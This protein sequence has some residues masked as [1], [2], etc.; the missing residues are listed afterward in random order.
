MR[1]VRALELRGRKAA[2]SRILPLITAALGLL[3][4]LVPSAARPEDSPC[5]HTAA[6]FYS[7]DSVNLAARLHAAPSNCADYYISLIPGSDNRTPRNG[8]AATIRANGPQFH[9]MQEVRLRPWG[10]WVQQTGNTWYQAGVTA[11][12]LMATAGANYDITGGDTWA[13]NEVGT[14]S[15]VDMAEAVFNGDGTARQD[16]QDFVRGLYTGEP[17]MPPAPGLVFVADPTQIT[18]DLGGY[19]DGLR[20]WFRDDA[21]W[22][23]MSQYVRFW[24]QET[25]ADSRN[26]G[27]PGSSLADRAAHLNDYFQHAERLVDVDPEVSSAARTFLAAAYTPVANAAY[28]WPAPGEIGF[29]S[30]DLSVPQMQNFIA[31]QMYALRS[32]PAAARF[33]FAWVPNG[34]PNATLRDSLAQSIRNSETDPAGACGVA[35]ALCDSSVDRAFFTE[36]WKTFTDATP[37]VVVPELSGP[38]GQNDWYVGDVTVSWGVSDPE[39]TFTTSGCETTIVHTDTAGTTFICS[40]TSLGGETTASVTVK[41]DTTAP[42][43]S[44]PGDLA[45]DATSPDGATVDYSVSADDP[46]AVVTCDSESGSVFPIGTTTVHCEAI[47][48]AGNI[49]TETFAVHVR[50]ADEQIPR[51]GDSVV[52]ADLGHGLTTALLAKLDA[53][54]QALASGERA[55]PHLD[56]FVTLVRNAERAHHI[57][58]SVAGAFVDAATRAARVAVC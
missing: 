12:T 30:T 2:M 56:A 35:F 9:A 38:L 47:D 50:G 18:T 5:V 14:P 24:A 44:V 17:G 51:L 36:A 21:F 29:G 53:A 16:F 27:V 28:R 4:L 54:A 57:E 52:A 23:D 11:R 20:R 25:Y 58:S 46:S 43:V 3:A 45:G 6:V 55:C 15:S 48:P 13:I 19:K 39:S 33:G 8:V 42:V 10:I 7:T 32:S 41:R 22:G 34:T 31:T 1:D 49:G 26:W 37:P 40:A